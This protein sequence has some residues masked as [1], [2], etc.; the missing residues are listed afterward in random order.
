[1]LL[2]EAKF[3][4]SLRY[5]KQ[6]NI[7]ISASFGFYLIMVFIGLVYTSGNQNVLINDWHA[8]F[9]TLS[10]QLALCVDCILESAGL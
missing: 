10:K 9:P 8:C 5:K 2:P 7:S 3:E 6:K 4:L 1:M